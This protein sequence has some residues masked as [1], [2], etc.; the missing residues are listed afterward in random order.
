MK[1]I[2][3]ATG[4]K[5]ATFEALGKEDVIKK[6][7]KAHRQFQA[8]RESS[9]FDRSMLLKNVAKALKEKKEHLAQT[10]TLEMGKLIN[11]SR[12][13]VDKCIWCCEYYADNAHHFLQD[14]E[15]KTDASKSYISYQPLGVILAIMPWNYPYWQ[16]IRFAAPAIMAGN[17]S[18]LKHASNV[19]QC[20]LALE[21]IFLEAGCAEGQFTTL[22][23]ST[24]DIEEVIAHQAVK[25]VTLTGSGLA[26]SSVAAMAG[27]HLKKTVLE[28]GGSDPYIILP[29][30]DVALAAEECAKARLM[31]T[32]QSCIGAKRFI[33]HE[34]VY[35]DFLVAFR[36]KMEGVPFVDPLAGVDGLAPMAS[37]HHRDALHK[38]VLQGI[39]NGAHLLCGGYIDP[40]VEGAYY[41]P[42]ILTEVSRENSIYGEEL[43]GP[44]AMI[45]RVSSTEEAVEIANDTSFGLGAAVFTQNLNHGEELAKLKLNAGSC[46]V[47]EQVKSDPRL[48][49]GGIGISGYGRELSGFGIREFVNVKT[50]YIK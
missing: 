26:G 35:E 3:P 23:M 37:L 41:P 7:D 1:S 13:E 24:D 49:F 16:V 31:N 44:V 17:T 5:I 14:E 6:I 18:L 28:L 2:N 9:L 39:T 10:A 29:N 42:T 33:I 20:A 12:S 30:A 11:D 19:S 40:K 47:N 32:G 15:I 34:D 46:F 27:K 48:P 43:F 21:E 8:F 22:L 25:G 36:K 4:E 38:Q 50:I 45:F